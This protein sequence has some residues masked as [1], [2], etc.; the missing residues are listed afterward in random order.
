MVHAFAC[1]RMEC[2]RGRLGHEQRAVTQCQISSL[3]PNKCV[4]CLE[5]IRYKVTRNHEIKHAD[6]RDGR[7]GSP[8]LC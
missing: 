5:C 1:G 2:K 7:G 4:K 3:K 6:G 8:G